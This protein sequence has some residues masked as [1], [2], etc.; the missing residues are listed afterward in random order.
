M[1]S[2]NLQGISQALAQ[3]HKLAYCLLLL[4]L[5]NEGIVC[6]VIYGFHCGSGTLCSINFIF[7]VC[8][9]MSIPIGWCSYVCLCVV[10]A[11]LN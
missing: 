8:N 7:T 11:V 4:L 1:D 9:R 3:D 5:L 10:F 2:G 6:V